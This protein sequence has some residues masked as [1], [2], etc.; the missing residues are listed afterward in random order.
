MRSYTVRIWKIRPKKNRAGT[1]YQVR[2]LVGEDQKTKNFTSR[3]LADSFRSDLVQ[4]V[5]AGE[6]FDTVTGLPEAIA[7][8]ARSCTWLD[9]AMA[10]VEMKWPR[11]S[12]KHR[13]GIAEALT[14][15]TPALISSKRGR[16]S[17]DDIRRALYGWAFNVSAQT[18]PP[19][20]ELG[21]VIDWLHKNTLRMAE[22]EDAKIMRGALDTLAL[23]LDG[24]IAA[25]ST[26][27]RKRAIFYNA[28]RYGVEQKLLAANPIDT[29]HWEAPAHDDEL[30]PAVVVNPTQ[31]E[32]LLNAVRED[33]HGGARFVAFFGCLYYAGM[34]PGEATALREENCVLPT[35]GWGRLRLSRSEPKAGKRWT[36]TG[37]VRDARGLKHRPSK[38]SR[39]VPIPPALVLMLREHIDKYPPGPDGR[40]FRTARDKPLQDSM[41]GRLWSRSR[42]RALTEAQVTSTL[43]RRP[44]DLR[45]AAVSTW[46]KA[47]VP[48]TE[49]AARAG[50]SVAVLLR[51]YAKC[52][53]G[54]GDVANRLIE[55]ALDT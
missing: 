21:K 43:G 5:R 26:I 18:S 45:H 50:H 7:R 33:P 15:V 24:K 41:Y 16:P 19:S 23:R 51:V 46:L 39:V 48:P 25:T 53:D 2:W 27:R 20:A 31:A 37:E 1:T 9:H 55:A 30:D 11:A 8:R 40:L 49:V 36:D 44:Y 6:P 22:L 13:V 4:A 10:Y 47:G 17:A 42:V 34:R 32:K 29:L 12:A 3:A 28:L 35:S 38:A 14:T 52:L 54:Q